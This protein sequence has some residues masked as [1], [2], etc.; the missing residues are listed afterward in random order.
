MKGVHISVFYDRIQE[1]VQ[2]D[3]TPNLLAH[4]ITHILQGTCRHSATGVLKARWTFEDYRIMRFRPLRFTE[5][6]IQLIHFGIAARAQRDKLIATSL[7]H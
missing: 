7:V 5:E 2:P 3:L 4:E 1:A 6:D